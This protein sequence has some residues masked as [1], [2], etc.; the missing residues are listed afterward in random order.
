MKKVFFKQYIKNP[1]LTGSVIP[2]SSHLSKAFIKNM[3][4]NSGT[5]LEVGAG[6]GTITEHVYNKMENKSKLI[7]FE[8]QEEFCNDL[9]KRFPESTFINKDICDIY[10]ILDLK[11]IKDIKYILSTV[12]LLSLGKKKSL[13]IIETYKKIMLQTGATYLQLTYTPFSPFKYKNFDMTCKRIETVWRN[14]PPGNI[15]KYKI[16]K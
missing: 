1:K 15:L 3:D 12:P 13:E 9:R 14:F 8:I 6:T 16:I 5:I 2:S 11:T 4:L 7:S 10:D